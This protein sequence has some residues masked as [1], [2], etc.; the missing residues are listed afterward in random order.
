MKLTI[1]ADTLADVVTW[2]ARTLPAR[3]TVPVLGG[4]L[5][6]AED[7]LTVSSFDY[8][9]SSQ[10]RV[11]AEV[12]EPGRVLLPGRLLAQVCATL[13]DKPVTLASSDQ[14]VELR[15]GAAEFVLR[16]MPVDDYPTLPSPPEPIGTVDAALL[17]EALQQVTPATDSDSALV[18]LTGV[19]VDIDSTGL[20]FAGTD[21]Y[22]LSTRSVGFQS[23]LPGTEAHA[24]VFVK[25]MQDLAKALPQTGQVELGADD[26][27]FS[28]TFAGRTMTSRLL[29]SEYPDYRERLANAVFPIVATVDVA[30]LTEAVKRVSTMVGPLEPLRLEFGADEVQVRGGGG[31]KGRGCEAV[32]CSLAGAE[33]AVVAFRVQFLLEGLRGIHEDVVKLAI[34]GDARQVLLAGEDPSY[35]YMVQALRT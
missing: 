1:D 17:R 35:R 12:A 22:R 20:Q 34:T 33:E 10:A 13:P 21:R 3:P 16:T 24:L 32:A 2:A 18:A 4:L 28:A 9:V 26:R 19:R 31:D 27:L 6:E 14:D 30:P 5:L 7:G 25:V 29:E 15:C 23:T 8:D 11:S